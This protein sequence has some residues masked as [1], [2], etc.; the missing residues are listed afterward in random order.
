M[1]DRLIKGRGGWISGW[2]V[3]SGEKVCGSCRMHSLFALCGIRRRSLFLYSDHHHV[4]VAYSLDST[5]E[6][7]CL[8]AE[9]R[10]GLAVACGAAEAGR[11]PVSQAART[12]RGSVETGEGPPHHYSPPPS[13]R[14]SLN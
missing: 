3:M 6:Y 12:C 2:T 1:D 4:V 11:R 13:P 9:A 7:H 8:V 14:V 10:V 5:L